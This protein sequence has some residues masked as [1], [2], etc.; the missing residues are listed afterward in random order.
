MVTVGWGDL[1]ENGE[2]SENLQQVT[3]QTVD[4]RA[5]TCSVLIADEQVQLCAGVPSGAK[6]NI[7]FILCN[8]NVCVCHCLY[9]RLSR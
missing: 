1:A 2:A 6:G 4:Y 9:R 3:L 5:S 7:S 8:F